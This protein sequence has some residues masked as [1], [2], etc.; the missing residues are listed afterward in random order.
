MAAALIDFAKRRRFTM[1]FVC[2]SSTHERRL[3][4]S[5]HGGKNV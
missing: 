2:K 1:F 5:V 4:R 3:A